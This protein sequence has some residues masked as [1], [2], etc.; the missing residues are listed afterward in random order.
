MAS[1]QPLL[2]SIEQDNNKPN[3]VARGR[4]KRKV[5]R[6]TSS[7]ESSESSPEKKPSPA[8]RKRT[9]SSQK[10]DTNWD[11]RRD[12][13]DYE[14]S[15]LSEVPSELSEEIRG[16]VRRQRPSKRANYESSE[17]SPERKPSPAKRKK[18]FST[19]KADTN[20]GKRRVKGYIYI[21][22]SSESEDIR[23]PVRKR[24]LRKE[25][26]TGRL[27]NRDKLGR[28]NYRESPESSPEISRQNIP[29][30]ETLER[31]RLFLSR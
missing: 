24:I 17:S 19:R 31:A 9:T 3:S 11:T 21:S 22:E 26:P 16:P 6:R 8:K 2:E 28:K 27:R 23:G 10:A 30:E 15:G 20:C 29:E 18:T 1:A 5:P 14:S 12:H 13:S 4:R 7:Y 25:S